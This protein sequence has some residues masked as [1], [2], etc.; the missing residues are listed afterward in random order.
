MNTRTCIFL[1]AL[2]L[3]GLPH[4]FPQG[5][6]TDDFARHFHEGSRQFANRFDAY[7]D[8]VNMEFAGYLARTWESFQM[9]APNMLPQKPPPRE[10]PVY[11]PEEDLRPPADTPVSV[12]PAD[13]ITPEP[14]ASLQKNTLE[15]ATGQESS[16]IPAIGF[17]GT[18]VSI[19]P[20]GVDA[21]T[22]SG[23]GERQIAAYWARLSKTPYKAFVDDL[24]GKAAA[25]SLGSWGLYRLLGEWAGAHFGHLRENEKTVFTVFMLNQAGYK[26]RIGRVKDSLVVMLAFRNTI[27]GRNYVRFGD[28]CYYILSDRPPVEGQPV[29]SY[30]LGYAPAV[31]CVDLRVNTLPRLNG[32]TQ[33][34]QRTHRGKAYTFR[35][36]RNLADYFGTFPQTE[37]KIYASTPLSGDAAGSLRTALGPDL[38][39]KSP[40]GKLEFLLSFVQHAFAYRTDG[41]QFGR[42]RFFFPEETLLFPYSDCEDRAAL[43]C[44]MVHL[45]CGLDTLLIEY[46]SHVAAAVRLDEP[47]DAV[48]YNS[49]R[50]IVCDPTYIGAP[51][52][53]TMKGCNNATAKIIALR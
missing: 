4:A 11:D 5:I 53:R 13:S 42:E 10:T 26:A 46:P 47:G 14:P 2:S 19:R 41:E 17:H 32:S 30:R 31:A 8:S 35:C 6:S 16:A 28:D 43:F 7:A 3:C 18:P 22:L 48:V 44:R 51:I 24:K 9:E 50:Y 20:A 33:A 45:F 27:Y 37:L 21:G 25:L 12:E 34:P 38:Q 15:T 52:A 23:T 36:N 29:A 40:A 39:G 49:E 1:S